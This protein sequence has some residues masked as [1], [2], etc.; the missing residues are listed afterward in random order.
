MA[1]ILSSAAPVKMPK[2]KQDTGIDLQCILCPK[3]PKFSDISH[4]LTHISSKSHLSHRFKLEIRAQNEI[5]CREKLA[6]FAIWYNQNNLD[7]LLSERMAAK[8]N[9]KGKKARVS[10]ASAT[11]AAV[12]TP[13]RHC[14]AVFSHN[15][16]FCIIHWPGITHS[17]QFSSTFQST[18]FT[19]PW[20][21]HSSQFSSTLTMTC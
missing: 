13:F 21:I 8:D 18:L 3:D 9:K 17:S 4:L 19:G 11:S 6:Q 1:D 5:E 2:T 10:D 15:L 20:I 12:S 16:S 7:S 14:L